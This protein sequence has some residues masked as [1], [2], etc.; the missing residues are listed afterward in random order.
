MITYKTTKAEQ[1]LSILSKNSALMNTPCTNC[2]EVGYMWT[3][4]LSGKV[5]FIKCDTCQF[6]TMNSSSQD[7]LLE[8]WRNGSTGLSSED[9]DRAKEPNTI[10]V[11]TNDQQ[12]LIIS[13]SAVSV[14]EPQAIRDVHND[15]VVAIDINIVTKCGIKRKLVEIS[16]NH[17]QELYRSIQHEMN[18]PGV[19]VIHCASIYDW[20]GS[21]TPRKWNE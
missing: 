17:G 9:A 6:R 20:N 8:Q 15:R 19:L 14:I 1:A 16:R 18:K 5:F 7:I 10:M 2:G 4:Q 21:L 3:T 11:L 13:K 12:R